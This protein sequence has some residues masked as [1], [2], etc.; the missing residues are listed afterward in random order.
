MRN[1]ILV[2]FVILLSAQAFS[3]TTYYSRNATFGGDWDDVN[4]WTLNADGSGGPVANYPGRIDHIVILNGHTIDIS[5]TNDNGSTGVRP[6]IVSDPNNNIAQAPEQ[7]AGSNT[8]DF[9]HTGDITVNAGGILNSTVSMMIRGFTTIY[10][11]FSTGNN[12]DL[13][14][15]GRLDVRAGASFAVGD[16]FVLSGN[17]ETNIDI[18]MTSFDDLYLD[19]TDALLCGS[20]DLDLL[21]GPPNSEIQTFNGADTDLQVCSG[22]DITGCVSCPFVGGGGFVLP[23]DLLFFKAT[24]SNDQILVS[25]STASELNNDHFIIERSIDGTH[26]SA[27]EMIDGNGTKKSRTDYSFKDNNPILGISFY[28]LRQV[29]YD[30]TMTS[31]DPVSVLYNPSIQSVQVFPNPL[32]SNHINLK[33][34]GLMKS[35]KVNIEVLD[36][37]GKMVEQAQF[38]SDV[39][40]NLE[41]GHTFSEKLQPGVYYVRIN[42]GLNRT[43]QKLIVER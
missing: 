38:K 22:F 23:V 19:D 16:D 13:V 18:S 27:L 9:Y 20:G 26:Y 31:Y 35:E 17:S 11:S 15:I 12:D 39:Y 3:Q 2:Q 33:L 43:S 36:L 30:G 37:S 10:G 21:R 29:D 7:F 40:G 6:D 5:A 28:K 1:L 42:S 34:T 41:Q 25:F 4:S 8:A 24:S 14:N 32:N